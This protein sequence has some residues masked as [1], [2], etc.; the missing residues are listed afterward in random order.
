[1]QAPDLVAAVPGAGEAAQISG[2]DDAEPADD[3][4]AEEDGDEDDDDA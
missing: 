2:S 4:A 1:L 3:D